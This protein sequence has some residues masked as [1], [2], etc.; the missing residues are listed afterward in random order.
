MREA[1][2]A[3]VLVFRPSTYHQPLYDR[4]FAGVDRVRV[5]PDAPWGVEATAAW[6]RAI[7]AATD[8][9]DE[10]EGALAG[11]LAAMAP[12]WD[13][14]RAEVASRA[15]A[16]VIDPSE[17]ARLLDPHSMTGLP[18]A[19]LVAAMGFETRV[20]VYAGHAAA[21]RDCRDRVAAALGP[22]V[23][24]AGFATQEELAA[25]LLEPVP[26][27]VY[28]EFFYDRRLTR[29]G[30]HGFSSRDFEM[31]LDGAV[32]SLRRLARLA[33]SPFY[34]AYARHMGRPSAA[35]WWD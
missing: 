32:R 26:A 13:R 25:G 9:A 16:F 20:L 27:I 14:L 23:K 6:V 11:R 28:S 1:L 17:S 5:T 2:D 7:A 34:R 10:A 3:G 31:G 18:V 29:L 33:A 24:V 35:W 15:A 8:R 30:L 19:P 22:A 21:F 4:V 12:A